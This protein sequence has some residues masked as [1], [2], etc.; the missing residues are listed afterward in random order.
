M[1]LHQRPHVARA[2]LTAFL[3][4]SSIAV[5]QEAASRTPWPLSSTIQTETG[6]RIPAGMFGVV[7]IDSPREATLLNLRG[8]TGIGVVVLRD[9]K[10]RDCLTMPVRFVAGDFGGNSISTRSVR[11]I[12]LVLQS[13]RVARALADGQDVVSDMYRISSAPDDRDADIII[14]SGLSDSHGFVLN[15]GRS[16]LADILGAETSRTPCSEA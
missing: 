1:S 2:V 5:A 10:S 13:A 4:S 11:S 14:Q 7:V 9:D 6:L 12:H 3:L 15:P 16:V 8:M